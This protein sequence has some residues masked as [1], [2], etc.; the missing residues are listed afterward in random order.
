MSALLFPDPPLADAV[1][2]LRP[3]RRSDVPQRF[4][5]FCDPLCLRFSWPLVEPFA[6]RHVQRRFDEEEEAR[7][8]GEELNLAVADAVDTPA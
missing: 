7:L 2:A 6:E 3:W 8:C 1:V 5:G 4:A